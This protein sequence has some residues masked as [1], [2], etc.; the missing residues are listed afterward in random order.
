MRKGIR[1]EPLVGVAVG[2]ARMSRLRR[3]E[4]TETESLTARVARAAADN[5][6]SRPRGEAIPQGISVEVM[7]ATPR[8]RDAC[9]RRLSAVLSGTK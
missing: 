6:R 7:E 3:K 2:P 1:C 4:M 5:R 9:L 8:D